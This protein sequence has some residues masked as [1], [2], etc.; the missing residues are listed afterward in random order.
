MVQL[1][2]QALPAPQVQAVQPAPP[3]LVGQQVLEDRLVLL[4][5]T[6]QQA[7]QEARGLREELVRQ[8]QLVQAARQDQPVQPDRPELLEALAQLGRPARQARQV[9]RGLSGA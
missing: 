5:A 1:A 6:V 4:A 3:E 2:R 8:D 9:R 7:R